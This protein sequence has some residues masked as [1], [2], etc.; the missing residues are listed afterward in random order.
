MD[1]AASASGAVK[2][3]TEMHTSRERAGER[4]RQLIVSQMATVTISKAGFEVTVEEVKTLCG[5][6]GSSITL[7]IPSVHV[8]SVSWTWAESGAPAGG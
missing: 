8:Y 4:E 1:Q 6:L 3:S 2:L 5:E 7:Y